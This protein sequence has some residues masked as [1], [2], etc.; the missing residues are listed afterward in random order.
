MSS[1]S[2]P[3]RPATRQE[4]YDRLRQAG[5]RDA[6]LLEEM[7]R[8]GFWPSNHEVPNVSE[9][10]ILR[11]ADLARELRALYSEHRRLEDEA[12]MLRELRKQRLA[13]SRQRREV[14][15]LRR[16]RERKD[17]ADQRKKRQE[18]EI[19]YLGEGV[20]GGLNHP[21][22]DEARLARFHLPVLTDAQ[23]VAGSLGVSV[24]ELR[25]LAFSRAVSRTNHY[26]RFY[27]PKKTGGRRL[28]SAPMPRLKAAQYWILENILRLVPVHDAAHGF[29]GGR[30]IVSNAR[31]HVG[32][33]VVIN[34]DLKDFFPTVTYPRVRGVFRKLG[35]SEAAATILALLCTEPDVDQA[36]LDG[37]T[38]FIAD[39]ERHLPQGAPTSPALTNLLC[40]RLDRR[41]A[42]LAAK[43]GFAYTRYADDLTFSASG[44]RTKNVNK[45]RSLVHLIVE[46]EDFRVHPDKTRVMRP[47][48][49]KEVTGIIVNDKPGVD[50]TTLRKFRALLHQIEQ[51]GIAG[52]RWGHT[53]DVL[54]A[55]QG[56]ARFV[57]MVDAQKGQVL[58]A[59][60][61]AIIDQ[62][63]PAFAKR[64]RKT[65][66][67][68]ARR[69]IKKMV[70]AET[71]T[72]SGVPANPSAPTPNPEKPQ[73]IVWKLL[74]KLGGKKK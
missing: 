24:G 45:L 36:E 23:S 73:G 14:T 62:I 66:P 71:P 39:G 28:I 2:E 4:L 65:Y 9:Q 44:E 27:L 19:G 54:A 52:K 68:G 5:T 46:G 16:E 47:G 67:Q 48:S 61:K 63:E 34:L 7:K 50:R 31:P 64:P 29:V 53:D 15:K 72:A 13:E 30:S 49:R 32:A 18:S 21:E 70:V 55:I 43:L 26:Q 56:Y 69:W 60:V 40:T 58:T 42:G 57:A 35:Y 59:R 51:E 10:F 11:E 6:F 41:L 17:R 74:G 20:S 3:L 33:Q 37:E 8:L 12:A 1:D 22:A 38:W 25:F